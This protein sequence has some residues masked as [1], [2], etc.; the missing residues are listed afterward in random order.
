MKSTSPSPKTQDPTTVKAENLNLVENTTRLVSLTF[1]LTLYTDAILTENATA[2]LTCYE[3]FLRLCP[4]ENLRFYATEN[5]RQHKPITDRT[6]GMLQTWLKP[7]APPKDFIYLELKDG[8][9]YQD[10]PRFK[11]VVSGYSRTSP[12]YKKRGCA[13]AISVAFPNEW[14]LERASELLAF[15][16][17]LCSVFPFQS[18]HAGFS[19]ECSPYSQDRSRTFAWTMSMRHRGI[20]ISRVLHDKDAVG[21]DAA[22]G[23]GWLTMIS[24]AFI[25]KLGGLPRIRASLSKQVDIIDTIGGVILK[26]GMAPAMGDVNR[27]DLLPLYKEVYH[28]IAPLVTIAAKRSPYLISAEKTGTW[29]RR[30]ADE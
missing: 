15:V 28:V 25:E 19:Y 12:H 4:K 1:G 5:M 17:D 27:R 18:G 3:S 10:A 13:N 24:T 22:K 16:R 21:H 11:F 30:F 23:V 29:F 7:G 20:D 6:F 14:G 8:Q 2:V 26:A 9:N